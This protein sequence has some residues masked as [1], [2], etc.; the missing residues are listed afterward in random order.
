MCYNIHV[1]E[2]NNLPPNDPLEKQAEARKKY[3][4]SEKGKNSI[5]RYNTSPKGKDTKKKYADSHLGQQARLRYLLSNKGKQTKERQKQI[6]AIMSTYAQFVQENPNAT[7]QDFLDTQT[8]ENN[9][10]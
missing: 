2:N 1:I 7:L 10:D 6:R 3:Y 4:Q 9:D 5:T 8:N